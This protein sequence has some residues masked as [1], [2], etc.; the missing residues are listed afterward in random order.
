MQVNSCA[1]PEAWRL[2]AMCFLCQWAT[3]GRDLVVA[4]QNPR[5]SRVDAFTSPRT[6][7]V[8]CISRLR[9][10]TALGH[11]GLRLLL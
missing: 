2:S 6:A 3:L 7:R 10:A 5:K 4:P 8:E 11:N 1:V 9:L